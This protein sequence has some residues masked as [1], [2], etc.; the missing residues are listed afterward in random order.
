M[1]RDSVKNAPAGSWLV[2]NNLQD[3]VSYL[4]SLPPAQFKTAL[5]EALKN[6]EDTNPLLARDFID[7]VVSYST[8]DR[9]FGNALDFIDVASVLPI[10]KAAQVGKGF[11]KGIKATTKSPVDLAK[12]AGDL[13]SHRTA[14]E[15]SLV[16]DMMKGDPLGVSTL[17]SLG[18]RVSPEIEARLPSTMAPGRA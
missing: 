4:Y 9:V 3:Q 16:Q 8:S 1:T 12:Q 18:N 5:E 17:E 14:T 11:A 2:G 6:L 15:A 13:G 10:S 7:A